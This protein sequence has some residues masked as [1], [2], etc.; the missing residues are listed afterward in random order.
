VTGYVVQSPFREGAEVKKGD[1]LFEVDPRPYQAQYDLAEAQLKLYRAQEELATATFRRD[2]NA[3][4]GAPGAVSAQ[5]LDQDRAAVDE[6]KASV[7]ASEASLSLY[8][9]NLTYTRVTS[10]IDGQVS[11]YYLTE[12]NIVNQDTTVLTSVVSLDPI[13]AY[14]EVDEPT[15]LRVR[16]AISEGTMPRY[17]E[18][19][20]P[21]E[22][23]LQG[24]VGFPHVG[25]LDFVNN[26]VNPSTAT[27]SVRGRFPNP[28]HGAMRLISPGMYVRMRLRIGQPRPALLVT[29]SAIISDQGLKYVYVVNKENKAVYTRISTGW[30]EA[31]GLRVVT[32]GLAP[33]D[34]IVVDGLQRVQP[35][36]EVKPVL[37]SMPTLTTAEQ[38]AAK[39]AA[40]AETPAGKPPAEGGEKPKRSGGT[41]GTPGGPS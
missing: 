4:E 19:V 3:A 7:R 17:T 10:P 41:P 22:L 20:V 11:R 12:G 34:R 26:Q 39:G 35:N 2:Q 36:K 5:Q 28:R 18:A 29:D 6:A 27:I 40:P 16:K 30:L 23:A 21:V 32:E 31:D 33:N 25:R 15:V 13:Y 9:L 1:L 37:G 14:C 38:A 24:E 8:K